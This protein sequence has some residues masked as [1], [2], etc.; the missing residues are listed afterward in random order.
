MNLGALH[1]LSAHTSGKELLYFRLNGETSGANIR[2]EYSSNKQ[3]SLL[4]H[5]TEW[6]PPLLTWPPYQGLCGFS[7]PSIPCVLLGSVAVHFAWGLTPPAACPWLMGKG[8]SWGWAEEEG[9][10]PTSSSSTWLSALVRCVL[11][12]NKSVYPQ[13]KSWGD[14]F[15]QSRAQGPRGTTIL[16]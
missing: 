7:P 2:K 10:S 5:S 13:G 15:F 6:R 12:G 14:A 16:V 4:Y 1:A 11:R 3:K 9:L 8:C